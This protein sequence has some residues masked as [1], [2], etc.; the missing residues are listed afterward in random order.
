MTARIHQVTFDCPDP[1]TLSAFW[2]EVTGWREDP[3]D[4]NLPE[5]TEWGL[6]NPAGGPGLLFIKTGGGKTAKNRLHFDII[7][8]D[9]TRDEEV[10]RLLEL[11]ATVFEDHRKPDGPGWVTMLDPEGNE[12]C[13]ERSDEEKQAK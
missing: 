12:F 11:G 6:R 10:E 13:V 4:P 1:A 7:P 8:T 2:S 3:D 9:R 5:H